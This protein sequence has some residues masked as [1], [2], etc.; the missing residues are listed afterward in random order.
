[1][2]TFKSFVTEAEDIMSVADTYKKLAVKH[3]KDIHKAKNENQRLYATKMHKRSLEAAKMDNHTDALNH[4]RGKTVK[5]EVDQIDEEKDYGWHISSAIKN[6]NDI[7]PNKTYHVGHYE[8]L[9]S[10]NHSSVASV[11]HLKGSEFHKKIKEKH[12]SDG[13]FSVDKPFNMNLPKKMTKEEI[14]AEMDSEGYKGHRG[15]EDPGKGPEQVVKAV[16]S[17]HVTKDAAKTL[18]KAMAQAH[19]KQGVAEE[20]DESVGVT[21]YNPKSQGGTRNE[22]LAKY[23]K[24]NNPKYAE[25][26]RKAGATQKELKREEVDQIDEVA[27]WQRSEGK[28]PEGGL[29]K[30]GIQ[31]YRREHPGSKLSLAVT[32]KPSKLKKGS[33]AWNRR[34]SF[35]ARMSGMKRRLT[36]AKTA[37]DPD[38]RINKS[39]R[40]WNC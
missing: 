24:T 38:S 14:M 18:T 25:A 6:I 23:H 3:M 12:Y 2:K 33:K 32:T 11:E 8:K 26:A 28:N 15:N 37:H 27:A 29:N 40:K 21:D 17:K 4:Y 13:Q 30:K 34:K 16:K 1:M 10:G 39:L 5:E 9:P 35:C 22:L 36:S 20:V 31:S 19:K 7:K